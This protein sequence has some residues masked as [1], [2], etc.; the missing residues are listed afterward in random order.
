[1]GMWVLRIA[2]TSPA[3]KG[4]PMRRR[5][6]G[7]A[8]IKRGVRALHRIFRLNRYPVK[9]LPRNF[10]FARSPGSFPVR[11]SPT[12]NGWVVRITHDGA[13]YNPSLPGDTRKD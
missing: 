7:A 13:V 9:S 4:G 11:V 1:M 10:F 5:S 3:G 12:P 6:R 8:K 2:R